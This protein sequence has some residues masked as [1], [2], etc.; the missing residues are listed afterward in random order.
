MIWLDNTT[1]TKFLRQNNKKNTE[2]KTNKQINNY[3]YINYVWWVWMEG[4]KDVFIGKRH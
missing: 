1:I 3:I 4:R 2:N